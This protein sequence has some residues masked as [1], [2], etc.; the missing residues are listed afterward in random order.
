[1][2]VVDTSVGVHSSPTT[3]NTGSETVSARRQAHRY[4]TCVVHSTCL[5]PPAIYMLAIFNIF[6][7]HLLLM[8]N[9]VEINIQD[10]RDWIGSR[11][12]KREHCP[13]TAQRL[14]N[15]SEKNSWF[16][17]DRIKSR[18]LGL[19]ILVSIPCISI[20]CVLLRSGS[21]SLV[22][23][24]WLELFLCGGSGSETLRSETGQTVVRWYWWWIQRVETRWWLQPP[25]SSSTILLCS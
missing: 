7:S 12:A 22:L 20:L 11:P 15:K 6:H 1:M 5:T 23:I 3:H 4:S 14:E 19:I 8:S 21:D 24:L 9:K 25:A 17:P 16:R 18:I 13:E 10:L 2:R